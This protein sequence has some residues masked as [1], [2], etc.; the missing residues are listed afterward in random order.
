MEDMNSLLRRRR[1]VRAY[2]DK[3]VEREKCNALV[4]AALL[5]PTAK[6][7]RPWHFIVVEEASVLD[8]LAACKPHGAAFLA[9]A[10]LAIVVAAETGTAAAWIEDASIA[11]TIIQLTA[12][13]LGLGSCWVQIRGRNAAD[14]RSAG[15]FVR[16]ELA[17]AAGT[18][19]E[20]IIALGYPAEKPEPYDTAALPRERVHYGSFGSPYDTR[21]R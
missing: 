9:D 6:N 12:E 5:S 13:E 14:G 16:E 8:R 18:E 19:V 20:A 11:A 1:S 17:I 7:R 15:D 4:N 2:L 21:S 10:P 3:A